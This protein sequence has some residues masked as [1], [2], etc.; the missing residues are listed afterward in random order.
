MAVTVAVTV[1]PR[2]ANQ[3]RPV[4]L[5]GPKLVS[6]VGHLVIGIWVYLLLKNNIG[7][8][9]VETVLQLFG[10]SEDEAASYVTPITGDRIQF[11]TAFASLYGL[12]WGLLGAFTTNAGNSMPWNAT[13]QVVIQHSMLYFL[14]VVVFPTIRGRVPSELNEY[15]ILAMGLSILAGVFQHGSELQR[16]IFKTDPANKGKLHTTGLFGKA[17]FINHTGHIL[18]DLAMA[19]AVRSWGVFV[20]ASVEIPFLY[21][22]ITPE[23]EAHMRNKYKEKYEKYCQQTPYKFIPY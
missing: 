20:F 2:Q 12:R 23:T 5:T 4:F 6:S 1:F 10:F 22:Q 21:F 13:I 14:G 18:Q 11:L 19:I 8:R 3:T 7:G 16:L 17:R 9:L 15:D